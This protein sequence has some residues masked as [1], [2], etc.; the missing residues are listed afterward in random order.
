M[1]ENSGAYRIERRPF[2]DGNDFGWAIKRAPADKALKVVCISSDF[3]G[4]RTH[5]FRGRTTP[6]RTTNCEA[7][8]AKQLSRWNGYLLAIDTSDESPIVFEFTPPGAVVLDKA[9]KEFGTSRGLLVIASRASGR[10]NG[11]VTLATKGMSQVA[12][13]LPLE[14]ELW[15]VLARIWG[16]TVD[17]NLR[18][19]SF[20]KESLSEHEK[21]LLHPEQI[22]MAQ[23]TSIISE[24]PQKS[25][26]GSRAMT[27]GHKRP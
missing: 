3:F 10:V 21:V 24:E 5:Y 14:V 12:H 2:E 17:A 1:D 8:D 25:K 6:C 11:K 16:L 7:C 15:P 27:N 19:A 22:G 9:I 13:K 20:A 4:V 26:G 23:R 18:Q